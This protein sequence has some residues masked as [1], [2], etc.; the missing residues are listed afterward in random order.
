MAL[1]NKASRSRTFSF[2][3]FIGQTHLGIWAPWYEPPGVARRSLTHPLPHLLGIES[4]PG[5]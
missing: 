1:L 5:A 3:M 2:T 4:R